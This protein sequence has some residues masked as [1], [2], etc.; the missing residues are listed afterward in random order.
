MAKFWSSVALQE[1]ENLQLMSQSFSF[2][3]Y[4]NDIKIYDPNYNF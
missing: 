4:D 3:T 2:P 1:G